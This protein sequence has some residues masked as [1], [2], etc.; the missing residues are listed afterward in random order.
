MRSATGLIEMIIPEDMNDSHKA[1]Q[2]GA[3]AVVSIRDMM[4]LLGASDEQLR[5]CDER[6]AILER[7]PWRKDGLWFEAIG[8][9]PDGSKVGFQRGEIDWSGTRFDRGG[10]EECE[11]A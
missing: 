10:D 4:I 9:M 7:E 8:E 1:E 3:Q 6:K 2:L 5:D 11:G